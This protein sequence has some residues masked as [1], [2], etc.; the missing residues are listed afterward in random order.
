M[1]R[2]AYACWSLLIALVAGCALPSPQRTM[3]HARFDFALIGD[4]PYNDFD[5]TNSFPNMIAEINRA[6]LAFVVH[7]GDIKS[8]SSPCSDQIFEERYKQFQSFELP[9]VYIFG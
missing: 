2:P 8:G 7:D 1:P 6:P 4:V 5:A 3:R 9:M